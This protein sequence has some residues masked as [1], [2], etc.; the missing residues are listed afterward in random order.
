MLSDSF[1]N[2]C[3]SCK[4][5]SFTGFRKLNKYLFG[6]SDDQ[7]GSVG[8]MSLTVKDKRLQAPEGRSGESK[9]YCLRLRVKAIGKSISFHG[10]GSFHPAQAAVGRRYQRGRY[11]GKTT[12]PR[13]DGSRP[14]QDVQ[15]RALM[16]Q[17]I[18]YSTVDWVRSENFR[19]A[20]YLHDLRPKNG[21]KASVGAQFG[22]K[23]N[24]LFCK[25]RERV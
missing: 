21:A 11:H 8:A 25:N 9:R 5:W 15:Y 2:K 24:H 6:F 14:A 12:P 23:L 1:E 10:G 22:Y 20:Y 16:S 7:S 13:G 18:S 19:T 17:P 4:N 3:S